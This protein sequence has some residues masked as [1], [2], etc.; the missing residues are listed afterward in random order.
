MDRATMLAVLREVLNDSS[1]SFN[2][3]SDARLLM[4]L[5]EGQDKFC[6]ETG[7]FRDASSFKL[8]LVSG[9]SGYA[10]PDRVIQVMDI[11]NDKK[12]LGKILTGQDYDLES[13]SDLSEADP[14]MPQQWRTD[15][16]TGLIELYP[17]PGDD[18]AGSQLTLRVWRYSQFELT[19]DDIDGEDTPAAPEIPS[20]F[21]GAPI[22]WAA[23]RALNHHDEETQ[24]PVK[25]REHYA[26]FKMYCTDGLD[27]FR[28]RHNVETRLSVNPQYVA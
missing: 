14:G 8:T 22:E 7:Y 17:T 25:A 18:Q 2:S 13:G 24:D 21:H 9:T 5:A 4:Y 10:I 26:N 19:D 6:E 20:R 16:D 27:H 23:Y 12:K 28:R 15:L 3:W 11:Y 1:T